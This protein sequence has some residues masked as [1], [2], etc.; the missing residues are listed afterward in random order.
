VSPFAKIIRR[1]IAS[2]V[3]DRRMVETDTKPITLPLCSDSPGLCRR[4]MPSCR[5]KTRQWRKEGS[6]TKANTFYQLTIRRDT[7]L[8]APK[9]RLAPTGTAA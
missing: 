6:W 7:A 5:L 1:I 8:I 2:Y 3:A 4:G 9:A